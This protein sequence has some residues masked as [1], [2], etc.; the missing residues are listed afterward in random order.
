MYTQPSM[1][2]I[3]PDDL[4][5]VKVIKFSPDEKYLATGDEGGTLKIYSL[6]NF[7]LSYSFDVHNAPITC[8]DFIYYKEPNNSKNDVY[9]LA[10]GSQDPFVHI[11]DF[12]S[13][14]NETEREKER[15]IG[16]IC[17]LTDHDIE[18]S[19][20]NIVFAIDKNQ[21][22]KLITSGTDF[23]IHFYVV[24]NDKTIQLINT[25]VSNFKLYTDF[26]IGL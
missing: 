1:T 17:T 8:M 3:E 23:K 6:D 16:D 20:S 18:A 5:Q 19:I 25:F 21:V 2:G 26:S 13:W 4:E 7:D 12:G 22:K 15:D 10:T 9:L 14:I 24:N 11:F